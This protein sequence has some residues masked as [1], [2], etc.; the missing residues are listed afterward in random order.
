MVARRAAAAYNMKVIAFD[1]YVTPEKAREMGV[2]LVPASDDV[3]RQAD[4]VSLHTPLTPETRGF[5]NAARLAPD[6][7][8]RLPDQLLPGG[9]RRR[10]GAL[11]GA[12][13]GRHRRRGDRRL[14]PGAAAERQPAVRAGEHHPLAAQRGADPGVR[15]PDGHRG[16][17]GRRGR[18]DRASGRSSSSTRRCSKSNPWCRIGQGKFPRLTSPYW[19]RE[20]NP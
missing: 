14:R 18:P 4:V 19:R 11:H 16:G 7:T 15:D 20:K 5:V 13:D 17:G 10:K 6:E 8:H 9:G 12:Q 1:P 2:T 3:F